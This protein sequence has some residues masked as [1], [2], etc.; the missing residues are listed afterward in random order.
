MFGGIPRNEIEELA[1][2]TVG[3]AEHAAS[4]ELIDAAVIPAIVGN[5]GEAHD[6]ERKTRIAIGVLLLFA[7]DFLHG[8]LPDGRMVIACSVIG[9]FN[10][11]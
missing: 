10:D 4:V 9:Y 6:D 7:V 8:E 1:L 5:R 2:A 11:F 3:I